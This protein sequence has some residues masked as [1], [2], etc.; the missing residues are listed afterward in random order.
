M[1]HEE[2]F[3]TGGEIQ[4]APLLPSQLSSA[5]LDELFAACMPKL[6][7]AAR[8]MMRNRQDSEDVLQDG[9]LSAFQ[10]L[11]QFQG[12][13]RFSTWVH[14]IVRNAAKMHVR[15]QGSRVFYSLEQN[16]SDENEPALENLVP[17]AQPSPEQYCVRS[18]RSEI[19]R[20]ALKELPARYRKA[21]ELCD[22]A[23]VEG[24]EAA[25]A[26]GVS[27]NSLKISLHRARRQV[28]RKIQHRCVARNRY[29]REQQQA[30]AWAAP[31][32]NI[33]SSR[34]ASTGQRNPRRKA[35]A[36]RSSRHTE[37][38]VLPIGLARAVKSIPE[39]RVA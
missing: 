16:L 34:N 29:P 21:I 5:E 13:S 24:K 39:E 14:S 23:G 3:T 26:M 17:D 35:G 31:L 12:R 33:A 32:E 38:K 1:A 11:R 20:A 37:W 7:M 9:L 36:R 18:E 25:A 6:S 30:E 10:N 19:L 4:I 27:L 22:I 2:S 15:K 8:K 28:S